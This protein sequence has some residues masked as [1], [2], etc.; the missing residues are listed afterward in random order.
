[1]NNGTDQQEAKPTRSLAAA[2]VAVGAVVLA[3]VLFYLSREDAFVEKYDK[4]ML[5]ALLAAAVV[6][7]ARVLESPQP[8]TG[9]RKRS[10]PPAAIEM[11]RSWLLCFVAL[12]AA[13]LLAELVARHQPATEVR[14]SSGEVL[15]VS[16]TLTVETPEGAQSVVVAGQN[17]E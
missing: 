5:A 10:V 2:I 15:R 8:Q 4:T 11:A 9:T 3:A 6:A 14:A 13:F 1:M 16:G 7:G 17:G 12:T